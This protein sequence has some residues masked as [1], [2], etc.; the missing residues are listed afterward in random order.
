MSQNPSQPYGS[1]N[2]EAN[3]FNAQ[4]LNAPGPASHGLDGYSARPSSKSV[5]YLSGQ[6]AEA[7]EIRR[8]EITSTPF[9]I[10]RRSGINL[11]LQSGSVSKDH[12]EITIADGNLMIRD[13]NSTNGTYVNGSRIEDNTIL[14]EGDLL[15]F[16]SLVF[17]L[18]RDSHATE[19]QT[20]HNDACDRALVMMQFD[21]LISDNGI[22][23]YFQPIVDINTLEVL[24]YEVLGRSHLFGLKTPSEMFQA[25]S[26]LSLETELSVMMR[27]KG[28]QQANF[29]PNNQNIFVNTHP[30]ELS[31]NSQLIES[32]SR[33]REICP[34]HKITLEIHEAAIT[35]P[36]QIINLKAILKD[37]NIQ[38]A[39]D[40][41]GVGRARL[42]ELSEVRPDYVKFDMRLT[43][44]IHRAT[45]KRQEVVALIIKMVNDLGI[46]SLA[47]GVENQPSHDIL[48]QMNVKT[49]QGFLYGH[50]LP[51]TKYVPDAEVE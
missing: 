42:V 31:K 33:M 46:V 39:F 24:G 19:S 44:D 13:L 16:A 21:R 20:Q 1:S 27:E 4:G 9:I 22:I 49:A 28:I 40:D 12:A 36:A 2:I 17:R 30:S 7:G 38:L 15:Q 10:G 8:Y 41:F 11:V 51:I 14:D 32:L 45:A 37:L 3:R 34:S 43:Q 50:P 6:T 48:K 25:A 26:R 47:E 18:S 23:P 5:W 35:N 29:F